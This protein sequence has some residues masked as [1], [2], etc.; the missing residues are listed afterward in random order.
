MMCLE[1]V[2][3]RVKSLASWIVGFAS[4][5]DYIEAAAA[6]VGESLERFGCECVGHD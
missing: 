1:V 6:R 2:R 4:D 5:V 3:V